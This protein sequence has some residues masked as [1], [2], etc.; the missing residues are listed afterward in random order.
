MTR[1]CV[2][3]GAATLAALATGCGSLLNLASDSPKVFGGARLDVE[4][5]AEGVK[6]VVAPTPNDK[7]PPWVWASFGLVGAVEL[8]LSLVADA[9]TLP[10]TI[11]SAYRR[12]FG[13]PAKPGEVGNSQ[14]AKPGNSLPE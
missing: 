6:D 13:P 4:V 5:A 3:I 14:E 8:P 12:I 9:L 7:F 10:I 1:R 2:Y 11:P